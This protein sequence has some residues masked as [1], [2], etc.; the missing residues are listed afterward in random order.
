MSKSTVALLRVRHGQTGREGDS[1]DLGRHGETMRA[2]DAVQAEMR[3]VVAWF[4]DYDLLVCP[5]V[6]QPP[7]PFRCVAAPR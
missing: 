1:R 4:D 3:R 2:M 7:P 5:T 6:A